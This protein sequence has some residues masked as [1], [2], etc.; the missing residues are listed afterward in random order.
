MKIIDLTHHIKPDMAV[1]PG[2]EQP[3][4]QKIDIE[5]YREL[6]MTLYT[7][8]GTH[9]D[10]PYHIINNARTLDAFPIDKFTGRAMV[11]DCRNLT[12]EKITTD[13]LAPFEERIARISFLLLNSGWH[14]K[15]NTPEYFGNFPT[16]T[17]EAAL[18]LTK[19]NLKGIGL[20]TISLDPVTDMALPNH[21]IVLKNEILIIENLTNLNSL[22][23]G[24]FTFQCFP[25]KI[26]NADG[27]PV[28]AVAFV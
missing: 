17:A 10:A 14:A 18:W 6:K 22:P 1:F 25:L 23:S 15:W 8:T 13:F 19:F 16:L 5:G 7:H 27:S 26:E 12:N 21:H 9:M 2:T 20:D 4:F 24:E 11:I 3:V 28:R